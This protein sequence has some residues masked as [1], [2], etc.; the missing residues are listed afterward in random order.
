MRPA[1]PAGTA[2][3][4]S[5]AA[6]SDGDALRDPVTGLGGAGDFHR[7]LEEG[8]ARAQGR[9]E[10]FSILLAEVCSDARSDLL[11]LARVARDVLTPPLDPCRI[12]KLRVGVAL[13]DT[14]TGPALALATRLRRAWRESGPN[15]GLA[16][17]VATW[18]DDAA[19]AHELLVRA[20]TELRLER[21]LE[22]GG[23]R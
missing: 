1:A 8:V 19:D 17:G 20:T 3:G 6:A 18:P 22:P 2:G 10:P 23:G 13:P 11:R 15:V 12:A 9:R 5:A 7:Q 16:V 14:A 21:L 4:V